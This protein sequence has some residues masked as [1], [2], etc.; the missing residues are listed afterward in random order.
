MSS[1]E[2]FPIFIVWFKRALRCSVNAAL[3]EA[4]ARGPVLTISIAE[5]DLWKLSDHAA[6]QWEFVAECLSDLRRDLAELAQPLLVLQ[7]D[8]ESV[9]TALLARR[10][11][12]AV[13]SHEETGNDWTYRRDRRLRAF[14][15]DRKVPW[16]ELPQNG[17]VRGLAS[18]DG[19]SGQ[20]ERRMR[21]P[22]LPAPRALPPTEVYGIDEIPSAER[23]GI[24]SD[25][26]PDRQRGGR[27]AGL[28]VFRSFLDER[29]VAYNK[30]LSSP[31]TAFQSCSRLSPH[32]AWG[33]LSIREVLQAPLER[34]QGAWPGP[35]SSRGQKPDLAAAL[36]RRLQ[37][38]A[39]RQSPPG[40]VRA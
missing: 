18:R 21:T 38:L 3:T 16:H 5:P 32:L 20:W 28:E 31:L 30:E 22:L 13:W 24:S 8:A 12:E 34:G 10:R 6:R 37:D 39:N 2:I 11:V 23:L 33:T 26:C 15:R 36:P 25:P 7:G 40:K 29:G 1:K 35:T 9:F 14:F 17:V 4:A 27:S 19:W